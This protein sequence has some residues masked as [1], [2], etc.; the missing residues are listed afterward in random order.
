MHVRMLRM[1][2]RMPRMR[3]CRR[4]DA[5]ALVAATYDTFHDETGARVTT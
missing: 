2:V 5:S 3:V 1:H 4:N